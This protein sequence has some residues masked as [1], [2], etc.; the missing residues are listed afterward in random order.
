[1]NEFMAFATRLLLFF[2]CGW[3]VGMAIGTWIFG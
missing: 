3:I 2:L 1:M